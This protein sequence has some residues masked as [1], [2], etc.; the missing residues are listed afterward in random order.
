MRPLV[1][2]YTENWEAKRFYKDA[3][4]G[5][6][7]ATGNDALDNLNKMTTADNWFGRVWYTPHDNQTTTQNWDQNTNVLVWN[8]KDKENSKN[9]GDNAG[10]EYGSNMTK[11]AYNRMIAALGATYNNKG[12]NKDEFST[13]VRF[14]NKSNGTFIYVKPVLR[15]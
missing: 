9:T 14:V 15:T 2:L 10:T 6:L 12:V 5:Y 1:R 13:V 3:E 11:A 7:L 4:K 8:L